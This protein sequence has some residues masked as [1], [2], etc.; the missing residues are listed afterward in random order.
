MQRMYENSQM[1]MEE[2]RSKCYRLKQQIQL[3]AQE[4]KR[5]RTNKNESAAISGQ[6]QQIDTR[7]SNA[8]PLVTEIMEFFSTKDK[9]SS[10]EKSLDEIILELQGALE[11]CLEAEAKF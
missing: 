8:K 4:S 5:Q 6:E 11:Q 2:E 3:E 9:T 7:L 10:N 1:F